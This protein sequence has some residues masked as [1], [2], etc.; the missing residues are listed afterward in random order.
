MQGLFFSSKSLKIYSGFMV[1]ILISSTW[2][3]TTHFLKV[4]EG[5]K[6][7]K[8]NNRIFY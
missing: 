1:L 7:K 3:S 4:R 2:V 8:K 6:K 5:F